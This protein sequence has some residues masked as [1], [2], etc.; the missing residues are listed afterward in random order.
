[1][2]S[3]RGGG[4]KADGNS[5]SE[6]IIVDALDASDEVRAKAIELLGG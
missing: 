3:R 4:R 5:L 2:G 6:R 1:M